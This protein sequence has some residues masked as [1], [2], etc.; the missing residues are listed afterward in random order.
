[1]MRVCHMSSAHQGLDIRIFAK[2]C[3]SLAD[4]GYEV[5]LVI[6]APTDAVAK[7][8]AQRVTMHVLPRPAGRLARMFKQGWRCYRMASRLN[9][10]IYH[11]HDPELI[12]YGMLLRLT[13]KRVIYDVHE[14]LP[15]DILDKEW[16]P[17]WARR[18]VAA[19]AEALEY[20]GARWFFAVSAA[21]PFIAERYRRITSRVIDI[22]N[23]PM[24]D[25]LAPPE[26]AVERR[27]QVCY[28]GGITRVRG[29]KP[30]VQA[31][32]AVTDVR[33][34]LCGKFTEPAFEAE[35]KALPGWRQV[36]YRGQVGRKDMQRILS[37]SMA[38]VVTFLPIP[39]HTDAQPNKMFEYMSAELPVLASDFPL[40][41]QI[42]DGAQA[43]V[44]VDPQSPQSIAAGIRELV[45]DPAKVQRMGKAGR[46]AVL[47]KYNWPTEA[48]KL[49]NFYK[50]LQ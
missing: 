2:E 47:E 5:H 36:D 26:V 39:N 18:W 33:L 1:M 7:A 22:N 20:I 15:R 10:D 32:P 41:R 23:F 35:I 28:V 25:E 31:L 21:T 46:K 3:V 16:I 19:G 17:A 37:E 34:V 8:A 38:G 29:L 40:W 48:E 27:R 50:E 49:V 45:G 4:A 43:G 30:L 12:P 42:V 24:P 9:A 6:T 44:C 14:D 11:F 13:G